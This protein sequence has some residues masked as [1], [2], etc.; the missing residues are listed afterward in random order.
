[1]KKIVNF[2]PQIQ[3]PTTP[4]R[5][6][7]NSL[8]DLMDKKNGT[9]T[10]IIEPAEPE[11]L[12]VELDPAQLLLGMFDDAPD[13]FPFEAS[14]NTVIISNNKHLSTRF[15]FKKEILIWLKAGVCK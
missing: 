4:V 11:N 8:E 1:M 5:I 9:E 6:R 14:N 3:V 10:A 2:A 15:I 12:V 7:P 13:P